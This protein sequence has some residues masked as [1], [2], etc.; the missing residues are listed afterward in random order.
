MHG[1]INDYQTK[2]F[3]CLYEK[4]HCMKRFIQ[5]SVF[6]FLILESSH[7]QNIV[8][9]S[10]SWLTNNYFSKSNE[11]D[12]IITINVAN[13]SNILGIVVIHDGK[14]I[15]ENYYNGSYVG[16]VFNIWS[17]TKS[18]T[19]TLI[20]Q[21][22]DMEILMNTDSSASDFL[23][24][25][26]L[27]FLSE[28]SLHNMLSMTSGYA[29]EYGWPVW[30][31]QST[32]TLISMDHGTP[33]Q[34]FYNNSA[35]HLNLHILYHNSGYTPYDF[36]NNYLFPYLGYENPQ[37]NSGFLG[38]ND[39]S[40][41]LHLTLRDMVKLG[42]LYIQNGYSG[43]NQILSQEWI[44]DATSAHVPT[45][46]YWENS[47]GL[48]K[49]G[50]LWWI[51]EGNDNVYLAFGFGGQ[52]IAVIPEYDLVIGTHS[53]DWGPGDITTHTATLI[54]I[55]FNG[56]T[57]VFES[58]HIAPSSFELDIN[59]N[60]VSLDWDYMENDQLQYYLLERSTD[61]DFSSNVVDNYITTN[62]YEDNDLEDNT[63]YFYR[64]SYYASGWSEYSEILSVMIEDVHT[65]K[66]FNIPN[67]FRL[68][69]NYP[70]P[71]NPVTHLSYELSEKG[72]VEID[73]FDLNGNFVKTLVSNRMHPGYYS[74][75]WNG[76]NDR[77]QS[78][79]AGV[80]VYIL[81][82]GDYIESKKMLLIK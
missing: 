9:L 16:D 23:P 78:V 17:V 28:I 67:R 68:H 45:G 14:I 47:Y 18:F 3:Y 6:S 81:K 36:A 26:D 49:Y 76:D 57:P 79:S 38:I 63:E 70:N 58:V 62:S 13:L 40:A 35:C 60:S 64:V 69:Q 82:I 41:S 73:I 4:D 61:E 72:L 15:S 31:Q 37:W 27:E 10:N 48:S 54:D 24:Q 30:Y 11:L 80:Y 21:A 39:G 7:T 33:G 43:S 59:G 25:F 51:P 55:I 12:S 1:Q 5:I 44:E 66:N 20:G 19:S 77:G 34:F 52:F 32:E 53:T 42:Q 65:Q 29:D 50:Y 2:F 75:Q 71:F 8:D 56:L 46:A 22:Y 74:V